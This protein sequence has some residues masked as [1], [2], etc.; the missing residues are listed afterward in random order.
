MVKDEVES[1]VCGVSDEEVDAV[2]G[3]L[4][5]E[6]GL[7]RG[8]GL[9][10]EFEFDPEG[11]AEGSDDEVRGTAVSGGRFMEGMPDGAPAA[12]SAF[13]GEVGLVI[14]F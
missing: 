13:E 8:E 10:R 9:V 1:F 11:G 12:F 6:S 2:S 3:E 14:G 5:F 4:F 7:V